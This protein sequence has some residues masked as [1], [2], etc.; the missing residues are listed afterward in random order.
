MTFN[1]NKTL[2]TKRNFATNNSKK[3]SLLLSFFLPLYPLKVFTNVTAMATLSFLIALRVVLQFAS[4]YI[5]TINMSISVAWTPVMIIG[6]IY[7]PIFGFI[8]GAI[9]DTIGF[10]IK[11]TTWFWLYAIQEP[12]VGTI[13]AV[14]GFLCRLRMSAAKTSK[15][16]RWDFLIFQVISVG[17]VSACIAALIFLAKGY[18]FEGKL[19]NL[20]LFFIQNSKWIVIGSVLFFFVCVQTISIVFLKKFSKNLI[21]VNWIITL[22]CFM[23]ILMSF[24]LGPISANEFYK[25]LYNKDSP[26]FVKYGA[27]F[28][29]IPRAIKESFKAPVQILLLLL[30][31]PIATK[32]VENIKIL[33]ICKWNYK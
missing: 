23:S 29:L 14:F 7:G 4:I 21:M 33:S 3:R 28:Y 26:S 22:V 30:T 8:S 19:S 12:M 32:T 13:A 11:P 2:E 10:L 17:F 25:Y 15:S 24:I 27:M 16:W 20:E 31:I 1:F 9:T 18:S 5:P 6:W